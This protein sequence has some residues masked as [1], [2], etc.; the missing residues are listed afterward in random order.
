VSYSISGTATF[1]T[2]YTALSGSVTFAADEDRVEVPVEAFGDNLADDAETV[3]VTLTG[4]GSTY[5]IDATWTKPPL[6]LRTKPL[7]VSVIALNDA[8]RG[9]TR[10]SGS[11]AAATYRCN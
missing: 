9:R 4:A 3:I 11:F 8:P 1:T 7:T 6:R 10:S 5:T 2:D